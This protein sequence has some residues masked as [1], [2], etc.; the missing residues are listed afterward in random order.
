M[1]EL[2]VHGQESRYYHT[3]IGFGARMDTL[4][5]AVILAKLDTFDWEVEQRIR[6]GRIYRDMVAEIPGIQAPI[7]RNDRT[8]VWAQFT[9][10][11]DRREEIVQSLKEVGI[12][13]AVHYPMPL[14]Q[15]P[16]YKSAIRVQGSL[17]QVGRRQP[18]GA[19]PADAPLSR[20]SDH[21]DHRACAGQGGKG[22]GAGARVNPFTLPR[23]QPA[24]S[25]PRRLI[26]ANLLS[27]W[28]GVHAG[29]FAAMS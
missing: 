13:T 25:V 11:T 17:E 4:Q 1:R 8:C 10:Q 29:G 16:A 6:I 12:P 27:A 28:A 7:V 21:A 14:H 19:E 3:R 24:L 9:I 18:P 23:R 2:R 22:L 15:Q 20:R 5:C 26:R